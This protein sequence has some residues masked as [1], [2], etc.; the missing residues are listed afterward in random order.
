AMIIT[1]LGGLKWLEE[2]APEHASSIFQS[3]AVFGLVL[4]IGFSLNSLHELNPAVQDET[5]DSKMLW[6]VN[7]EMPQYVEKPAVVLF[8]YRH[9]DSLTREPVY[10]LDVPWPDDAPVI[11]AH[12]L[13]PRNIEIYRYYARRQPERMFYL[14]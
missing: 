10:N 4:V 1:T 8:R 13:G 14:F 3:A 5:F 11:R 9:G 6:F 12:D 7:E 2:H